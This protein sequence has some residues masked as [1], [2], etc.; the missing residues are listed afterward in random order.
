M[1]NKFIWT[2]VM[3]T[4]MIWNIG[5]VILTLNFDPPLKSIW[6]FSIKATRSNIFV[7]LTLLCWILN[8][9]GMIVEIASLAFPHK[10]YAWRTSEGMIIEYL[11]TL[12][13]CWFISDGKDVKDI[14]LGGLNTWK[15]SCCSYC[16]M[17]QVKILKL[18]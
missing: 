12:T 13:V 1:L 9:P 6:Y 7:S 4:I 18:D 11:A 14:C 17:Q 10:L 3:A 5:L 8:G 16:F 2:F 15:T